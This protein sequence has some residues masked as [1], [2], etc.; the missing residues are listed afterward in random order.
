MLMEG[1][2]NQ[3][4]SLALLQALQWEQS[5][6]ELQVVGKGNRLRVF[7]SSHNLNQITLKDM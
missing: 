7:I 3:H 6:P 1:E 5:C 2:Q 4:L